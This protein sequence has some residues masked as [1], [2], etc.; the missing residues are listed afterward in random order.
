MAVRLYAE[1]VERRWVATLP[2]AY[3]QDEKSAQRSLSMTAN[4]HDE[5]YTNLVFPVVNRARAGEGRTVPLEFGDEAVLVEDWPLFL[6]I[7][8]SMQIRITK[9]LR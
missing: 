3:A 7:I 2:S 4:S 8:K 1:N 5:H 9:I 6:S